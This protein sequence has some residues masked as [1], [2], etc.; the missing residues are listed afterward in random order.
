[1]K[2]LIIVIFIVVIFTGIKKIY[3]AQVAKNSCFENIGNDGFKY[4][5]KD[6]EQVVLL[7]VRTLGEFKAGNIENSIHID[8]LQNSYKEQVSKLDKEKT[9]LVYCRSGNRS[10][11]AA[12][13]LCD[14]GFTKVY[15]LSNGY[16]KWK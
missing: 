8:V 14:L 15:N 9:Y 11:K 13:I 4:R 12:V 10:I 16:M 7:D 1:M 6:K 5:M 3:A 2:Y